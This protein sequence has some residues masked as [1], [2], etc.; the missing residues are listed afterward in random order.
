M[1]NFKATLHDGSYH[2]VDSNELSFKQAA[3]LAFRKGI[4]NADPVMLEPIMKAEIVIPE[5]YMG[6]IMGDINKRRGR[7]LGMNPVS[8]GEQ[9]VIAEVP[10]SEMIK[11]AT[12]LRSITQA[13]GKFE[14]S[15]E[16]YEE[17]PPH[18]AKKGN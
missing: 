18:L 12:D 9:K 14:L 10:Q 15:F 6:D 7:I 1:I 8:Q 13:R 2:S 11:Y 4:P 16:R 3:I 17:M 5:N